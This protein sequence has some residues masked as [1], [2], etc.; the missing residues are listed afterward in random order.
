MA[1]QSGTTALCRPEP[2]GEE[3]DMRATDVEGIDQQGRAAGC[4]AV[5][6]GVDQGCEGGGVMKSAILWIRRWWRWTSAQ[7]ASVVARRARP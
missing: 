2:Q 5:Q 4:L 3:H 7:C 1:A 6:E